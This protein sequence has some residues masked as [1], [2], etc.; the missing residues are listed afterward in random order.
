MPKVEVRRCLQHE[1]DRVMAFIDT[2]WSKGHI[3]AT[4]TGL[5]D[6]QHQSVGRDGYDYMV[7]WRG[8]EL[9]GVLG[10]INLTRY[11]PHLDG[12]NVI[13]LALWKV[14]D[15]C[16]V[17]G[18]G[19]S[20]L[21]A[22]MK[23]EPH[24]WI[25]VVGINTAHPPMYKALRFHTGQL[26]Q[27]VLFNPQVQPQLAHVPKGVVLPQVKQGDAQLQRVD[28]ASL[29]T[30]PNLNGAAVPAKSGDY[31]CR[32]FLEHPYYHYPLFQVVRDD[33][34]VGLLATR[35]VE[36]EGAKALRLVDYMGDIEHLGQCGGALL[37]VLAQQ[38]CEY[39]DFWVRL[40]DHT[41][42]KQA[43]F[44]AVDPD[45]VLIVPNY[46]EPFEQ[47]NV[48]MYY[49]FKGPEDHRIFRADGDQ[50]RPNRLP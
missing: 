1:R 15:D 37:E 18:L 7:A 40:A 48:R 47:R 36:H 32:R 43:G 34:V 14:R 16:G 38:Q 4:H 42:L 49:A 35:Q 50:D 3:M 13:W 10:Y 29:T 31:F 46:F 25:G 39:A 45:G 27:Y 5:F 33:Q 41:P 2:H 22:V 24:A 6:W 11:D 28:Q 23:Q 17:A 21:R 9:L 44:H 26:T 12:Q 8:E 19:L 30:W 20:L